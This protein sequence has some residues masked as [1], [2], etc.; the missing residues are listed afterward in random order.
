MYNIILQWPGLF[1]EDHDCD[2]WSQP[3]HRKRVSSKSLE[4]TV[5]TLGRS[6]KKSEERLCLCSR[7]IDVDILIPGTTRPATA[8]H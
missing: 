7:T 3:S 4:T 5:K 2:N 6:A 1:A 8:I